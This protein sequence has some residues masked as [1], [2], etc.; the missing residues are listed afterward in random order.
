MAETFVSVA[1]QQ[2]SLYALPA[3]PGGAGRSHR[4]RERSAN[5]RLTLQL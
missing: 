2:R 1:L 4:Y 5:L 3:G